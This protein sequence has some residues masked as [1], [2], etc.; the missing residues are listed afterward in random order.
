MSW[1]LFRNYLLQKKPALLSGAK[2]PNLK[3]IER[4][5]RTMPPT[6]GSRFET[7]AAVGHYVKSS[8]GRHHQKN[9]RLLR[10]P[11][12]LP[13]QIQIEIP[14]PFL[15]LVKAN[16]VVVI[17]KVRTVIHKCC[18]KYIIPYIWFGDCYL[19]ARIYELKHYGW[20]YCYKILLSLQRRATRGCMLP[21]KADQ[22]NKY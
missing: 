20:N 6:G 19:H 17:K 15:P 22:P 12:G 3:S 2:S 10:S 7:T 11:L 1:D 4:F 21:L 16:H 14:N 13:I 18:T 5:R 9:L 8:C